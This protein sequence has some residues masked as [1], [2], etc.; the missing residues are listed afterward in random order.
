MYKHKPK[1]IAMEEV[2]FHK[3]FPWCGRF[4]LIAKL[5]DGEIWLLDYKTSKHIGLDP[6]VQVQLSAYAMIWNASMPEEYHVTRIGAIHLKKNYVPKKDGLPGKSIK[7]L[8]PFEI[9][10]QAV[11]DT[12]R[13]FT[14][15]YSFLNKNGSPRV[16]P[17]LQSS[18]G[19]TQFYKESEK[20][21]WDLTIDVNK[22]RD[23]I[24]G[25]HNA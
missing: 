19:F 7:L 6:R 10:E 9:D 25:D 13:Q 8:Y 5:D 23:P 1:P 12:Y 20:K 18:F 21:N 22:L 11:W 24:K 15:Y 16:S 14:R 3:D 2:L 4:D 17:T